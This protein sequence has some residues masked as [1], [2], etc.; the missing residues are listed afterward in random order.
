MAA[1]LVVGAAV[2]VAIGVTVRRLPLTALLALAVALLLVPA[3]LAARRRAAGT[4]AAAAMA[5]L[6]LAPWVSVPSWVVAHPVLHVDNAIATPIDLW[7]DGQR[8][9]TVAPAAGESEPPFVRIAVGWHRIGWSAAGA[10]APVQETHFEITPFAEHLYTPGGAG[11]YWIAVTA[12]GGASTHGWAHGPQPLA[13]YHRLERVDVWF[14]PTPDVVHE[15]PL[16]RGAVRVAVQR[17]AA[18]MDLFGRCDHDVRREFVDCMR[19]IDGRRG[20]GTGAGDCWGTASK[21]CP[22]AASAVPAAASVTGA[23]SARP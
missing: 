6:A 11:C 9:L 17:W 23:T 5:A 7:I 13:D 20:D 15:P 10:S 21:R 3:A 22:T 8:R 12:Y 16:A 18:C 2:V 14:G 1:S 19:T 4:G